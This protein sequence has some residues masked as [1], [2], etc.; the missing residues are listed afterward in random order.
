MSGAII[1]RQAILPSDAAG[2]PILPAVIADAGL[3]ETI[4]CHTFRSTGITAYLSNGG[5]IEKAQQLANHESPKTTRLYNRTSD[6][7][8]L[9]EAE[10]IV[11]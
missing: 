11:I 1:S 9:D 7:I 4:C 8:T 5:T 2:G 10:R 3:P 6:Q